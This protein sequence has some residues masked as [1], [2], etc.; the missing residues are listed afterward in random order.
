MSATRTSGEKSKGLG[1]C[2]ML[3]DEVRRCLF[4]IAQNAMVGAIRG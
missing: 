2:S 1:F 3:R 4:E